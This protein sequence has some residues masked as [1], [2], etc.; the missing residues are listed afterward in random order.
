[1]TGQAPKEAFRLG[2]KLF[3][4]FFGVVLAAQLTIANHQVIIARSPAYD[5]GIPRQERPESPS[6]QKAIGRIVN[7]S[8]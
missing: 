5:R 6:R 1:M 2:R 8:W 4:C 7:V 3:G